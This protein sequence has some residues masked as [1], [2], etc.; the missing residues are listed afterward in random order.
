MLVTPIP[1]D[2]EGAAIPRLLH[3]GLAAIGRL[4][5]EGFDV[6]C[7]PR[8][9]AADRGSWP[10]RARLVRAMAPR[11][12]PWR[13]AWF[14]DPA[15]P[16]HVDAC[17]REGADMIH[18]ED[19]AAATYAFGGVP[20]VLTEHGVHRRRDAAAWLAREI[21]PRLQAAH[22][23]A[24]LRLVGA[25]ATDAVRALAGP[26]V[27]VAGGLADL[28]P[29]YEAAA[30]VATPVRF[31][32]DMRMKVLDAMPHGRPVVTTARGAEGLDGAP[33]AVGDGAVDIAAAIGRLLGS[34]AAR[35]ERGRAGRAYVAGRHSPGAYVDRRRARALAAERHARRDATP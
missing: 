14:W 30:V 13:S 32:G 28:G 1:P 20:A 2:R 21:L 10:R 22:P 3:D 17:V 15:A 4:R 25:E 26:R 7:T 19:S 6:R 16:R 11:G 12:M 5:A 24:R 34:P 9:E 8:R 31:G 35:A 33:V 27:D 18:V 23:E 29:A